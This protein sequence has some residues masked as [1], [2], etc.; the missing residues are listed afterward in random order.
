MSTPS[1]AQVERLGARPAEMGALVGS[2]RLTSPLAHRQ[3][4]WVGEGVDGSQQVV[5]IEICAPSPSA[6]AAVDGVRA[7][8]E[9]LGAVVDS[10]IVPYRHAEVWEGRAALSH[11]APDGETLATRLGRH[12][13]TVSQAIALGRSVLGALASAHDVG[14]VH[15]SLAPSRIYMGDPIQLVGFGRALVVDPSAAR[16]AD[17]AHA[18]RYLS[19]E[20][21]GL[22]AGDVSAASDLYA[23]GAVLYEAVAGRPLVLAT[24]VREALRE[25]ATVAPAPL[26]G[27]GVTAPKAFEEVIDRLLRKD[28]QHRYQSARAALVD[29]REIAAA[30]LTGQFE[31][32]FVI[33]KEDR[34][35]TLTEPAF[36]G[37]S[38]EL[39][40]LLERVPSPDSAGGVARVEAESG[41]GKSRLLTELMARCRERGVLVL[42]GQGLSHSAQRPFQL[43]SGVMAG[44]ARAVEADASVGDRLCEALGEHV[45]AACEALPELEETLGV[46]PAASTG[47]ENFGAARNVA[48]LAALLRGLAYT[49]R[50]TVVILDDCQWADALTVDVLQRLERD[51]GAPGVLVVLAFRTEEVPPEAPL[52]LLQ[53]DI[54]LGLREFGEVE[55]QQLAES[56]AGPLP[57]EAVEL[58]RKLSA[59]SPFMATAALRG[60]VETGTLVPDSN[61]WAIDP[62]ALREA[63]FS[64]RAGAVLARR[65]DRFGEEAIELLTVGAVIGKSFEFELAGSVASISATGANRALEEAQSRHF[66]WFEE[67]RCTFLHDRLR[68]ALLR[69]LSDERR[70]EIHQTI[71]QR[72]KVRSPD[73]VFDLAFHF[74]AA[75]DVVHALPCALEAAT[76]ARARHALELAEGQYR[77]AQRGCAEEDRATRYA[78]AKGLS[79]VLTLRG[80]Y[81]A[82]HEATVEARELAVD[83]VDR[84]SMDG[85]IGDL[86]FRQGEISA[87]I[88]GFQIALKQL[89]HKVPQTRLGALWGAAVEGTRQVLHTV[90]PRL[91]GRRPM[92]R[93]RADLLAAHVLGRL[94]YAFYFGRGQTLTLWSHLRGMNLA[95]R[96]PPT[97]ELADAYAIHGPVVVMMGLFNRAVSYTTKAYEISESL[98]DLWGKGHARAFASVSL[99]GAAR[100]DE[101]IV[102]AREGVE[103]LERSG[104]YWDVNAARVQEVFTLFRQGK[105]AECAELARRVHE[106]GL[107]LGDT[108][109]SG[110]SLDVW[111]RATGGRVPDDV[112]DGELARDRDDAQVTAQVLYAEAE[113]RLAKGDPA[114]AVAALERGMAAAARAGVRN[115]Y[116]VPL[117]VGLV[118][119]LREQAVALG[120]LE[121]RRQR[122][123]LRR[124]SWQARVALAFAWVFPND[125]AHALREAGL[126]AAV[127]GQRRRARRLLNRSLAV[128][129]RIGAKFEHAQTLW[130]LGRLDVADGLPGAAAALFLSL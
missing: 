3:R 107:E 109:A 60:L 83:P 44:L 114:A 22:V 55:L 2:V 98:G 43:F 66:L 30:L 48:A 10:S 37:R 15:G 7:L 84:A 64:D 85:R 54:D 61:G 90:F 71:A 19:P 117:R 36:V 119:M 11:P 33:G 5:A 76:R 95:E 91:V 27:L 67:G 63:Q 38:E 77:I 78:I 126:V 24:T 130:W 18:V 111:G 9:R 112:L 42:H 34:R 118:T 127:R 57:P 103:L 89:G 1:K 16:P 29:L 20:Q 58:V 68:E 125:R 128:A 17:P 50:R 56:M 99:Y 87:G 122:A 81:A 13:L 121:G 21:A 123:L 47:P 8:T 94:T 45:S 93:A 51:G 41:G 86:A 79:D 31:P 115:Q 69:R 32:A 70:R 100:Y 82:A 124:A 75:G 6:Q 14:V 120:P 40:A 72:L 80:H 113:R 35:A 74:D 97:A 25:L 28:P 104:D 129:D 101:C 62:T 116:T 102:A 46:E 23:L 110:F 26:R 53:A 96:Y 49:G 65:I 52:R 12:P 88:E 108:T 92:E 106:D 4:V 39:A 105:L 73:A 59:G